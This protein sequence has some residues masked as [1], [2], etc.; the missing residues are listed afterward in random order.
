MPTT[1]CRASGTATRASPRRRPPGPAAQHQH[2]L[3]ARAAI[4]LAER[5]VATCPRRPRHRA[6][7]ELGLRG[8]RPRVADRA[9]FTGRRGGLC[10]DFAYHGITEAIAALSPE[11]LAGAA[12]AGA[13]RDLGAAR[14]LPRARTST[15][16]S[17]RRRSSDLVARGIAAGRGDPGRRADERRVSRPRAGDLARAWSAAR[18]RAGGAVDRRRGAGRPRPHRRRDV[19]VRAARRSCRTSS[20]SASRWATAIRSAR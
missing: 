14:R 1:T 6:V 2:A 20:R 3:P 7:R 18:T 10:T 5:L 13:R 17:S 8:E 15:R 4:E 19:V 11:T 12:G 9:T 16:P